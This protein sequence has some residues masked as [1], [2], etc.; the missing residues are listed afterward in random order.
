LLRSCV[1]VI[2]EMTRSTRPVLRAGINPS[3]GVFSIRTLR[4]R[5]FPRACARSTL[6]PAG[7]PAGSVISNGGYASSMPISN[8]RGSRDVQPMPSA[9]TSAKPWCSH[10]DMPHYRTNAHAPQGTH[11]YPRRPTCAFHKFPVASPHSAAIP[12]L[13]DPAYEGPIRPECASASGL[14]QRHR[15][16]ISKRRN[17]NTLRTA[18]PDAKP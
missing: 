17:C 10:L 7:F 8:G 11:P 1:A 2:E 16:F 15:P 3:N 13:L 9:I 18:T 5:C 12:A 14:V 4:P 6:T